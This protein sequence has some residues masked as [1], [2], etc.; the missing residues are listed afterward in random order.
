MTSANFE[1]A[2]VALSN[3]KF[4]KNISISRGIE[5]E[6]LRSNLNGVIS[7]TRHPKS[8][9]SALTNPFITTDFAEA[10]IEMVTPTFDTVQGLHSFLENLDFFVKEN[11]NNEILWN[12]SMP[13]ELGDEK[14][15]Q[16]AEYGVSNTGRLKNIYR[17]GLRE[18]YGSAMQC[19]SGIHYNFSLSKKS[20]QDFF[21]QNESNQTEIDRAYF[22]LIRNVK[23][24]YWLIAY[25]FGASPICHQSFLQKR[26]HE[27]IER[28]ADLYAEKSTSLRMSD[29]GYQSL[30]Q[31]NLKISYDDLDTFVSGLVDG[32]K[33]PSK[34]FEK[35]GL[36]DKQNY[37][38]QISNGILQI[39][40]ELYDV[41]RPKRKVLAGERPA[42]ILMSKGVEYIEFRGLDINPY[43]PVGISKEQIQFLDLFLLHCLINES[44]M[45]EDNES[46][47]IKEN[48]RAVIYKGRD[49][50]TTIFVEGKEVSLNE[51]AKNLLEE[52]LAIGNE[53]ALYDQSLKELTEE[54]I[55]TVSPISK[56]IMSDIF[57]N[58]KTHC[59]LILEL[60]KHHHENKKYNDKSQ[61][62]NFEKASNQSIDEQMKLEEK[63]K[64]DIIEYLKNFNQGLR[65]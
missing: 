32:I 23:R 49:K 46:K 7:K 31:D 24:N 63:D 45:L 11:L 56:K 61:L 34:R 47:I 48:N 12:A 42:N 54:F 40:N 6:A 39:E 44:P 5:R 15:I 2:L 17:R 58:Q 27:L 33:N 28:K 16:I 30:E 36:F 25:L 52:I 51:A 20:W 38:L 22:G 62:D 4:F 9:G 37:P 59:E 41:V 14:Q 57:D 35:I 19:V 55:P 65:G 1:K 18:R 50:Q 60:S 53:M 3:R 26:E 64:I 10:L 8:L 29:I 43:E 13:C 21:N